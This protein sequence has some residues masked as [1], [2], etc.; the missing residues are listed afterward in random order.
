M[1][2]AIVGCGV[3]AR[4]HLKIIRRLLPD[5]AIFLC[6]TDKA[7]AEVLAK[8][9][10][11]AGVY[12]DLELLLSTERPDVVHI[13]TPPS[14]HVA[15]AELSLRAGAHV[16]IEKPVAE[17]AKAYEKIHDLARRVG[18][19]LASDYSTL[20]MPVVMRALDEIHSGRMG[21]L[22]SVHCSFAGSEGG[23]RIPYKDPGH[24]AYKLRGGVLQNM[25]DHPASLVLAAMDRVEDYHFYVSRRNILPFDCPDLIQVSL[26]AKDQVG[27]FSL[28]LGHGC[29]E[30]RAVFLL[31]GGTIV[32]DMGKQLIN[33][34]RANG[35]Q[36]FIKKALSGIGEGYAFAGGTVRNMIQAARGKLARDPGIHNV[37]SHFYAAIRGQGDVIVKDAV[38]FQLTKM[39]DDLWNEIGHRVDKE[40]VE[41]VH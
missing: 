3:I 39:L 34:N 26:K 27:S 14:T 18:R 21:R 19:I 33:I 31:D 5:A 28:S 2:V 37:I 41:E 13:L 12:S 10:E 30:R 40:Y 23:G 1:K 29:N 7:R 20:G 6:D 4:S 8:G 15:I 17:T 36:N 11:I 22:I 35:P 38:V 24:W 16:L 32:I 9:S 25:I